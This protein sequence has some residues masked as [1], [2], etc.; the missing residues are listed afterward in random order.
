MTLNTLLVYT[1]C[2]DERTATEIAKTL[3]TEQL[4][5]CVQ[6]HQP[7]KSV[8]RWKGE[9]QHDN[10]HLLGIKTTQACYS[11]LEQRLIALHPYDIPE[12]IATDIE[13]GS[14]PYLRWIE[15][16]TCKD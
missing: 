5:A 15:E 14:A 9:V 4:A 8:Y 11:A 6:I 3:V 1:T 16:N 10:E 13:R 12:I 7:V 2:P